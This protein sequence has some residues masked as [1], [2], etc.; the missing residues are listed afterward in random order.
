MRAY[1][2]KRILL[3][4]PT[5]FGITLISFSIIRLAPGD[6][7][8]LKARAGSE[9]ITD[10]VMAKKIVE[11]TQ[12]IYGLDK[13][14]LLNFKLWTVKQNIAKLEEMLK[15]GDVEFDTKDPLLTKIKR[16]GNGAVY[17]VMMELFSG[18]G[19]DVYRQD[20]IDVII[21]RTPI[22]VVEGWSLDEKEEYIQGWWDDH[23]LKYRLNIPKKVLMTFTEAQYGNW[24]KRLI[25]F[26]FGESFKDKRP[27]I[28][29]L[30]E[31]VPVD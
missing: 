3:M 8:V 23:E 14:I 26:D 30:K 13:P 22:R 5:L 27:V 24:V 16:A 6:P 29:I 18:E 10:Q 2:I 1:I 12:R 19:S 25:T 7:A 15:D 9:G 21:N 4:I 31:R 11:Q 20:L 17:P 28:D